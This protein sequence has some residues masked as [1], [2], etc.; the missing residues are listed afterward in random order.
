MFLADSNPAA[1]GEFRT[2]AGAVAEG[3]DCPIMEID[4]RPDEREAQSEQ[5]PLGGESLH[6]RVE[7]P[8][9]HRGGGQD[10]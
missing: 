7:N 6:K 4:Q 1:N 5:I 3:L 10:R 8:R 9:Q 2:G